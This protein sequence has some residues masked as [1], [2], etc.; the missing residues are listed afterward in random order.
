MLNGG[1]SKSEESNVPSRPRLFCLFAEIFEDVLCF[2]QSFK[3]ED[4]NLSVN[5][6]LYLYM[7]D[8]GTKML[9]HFFLVGPLKF[10]H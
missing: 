1:T 7:I 9:Q 5:G 4:S 2:V 3:Q 10:N 8:F 6:S